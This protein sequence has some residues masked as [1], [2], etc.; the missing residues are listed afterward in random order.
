V[1]ENMGGGWWGGVPAMGGGPPSLRVRDVG[2]T[3]AWRGVCLL[4][5][6][7]DSVFPRA[8]S[9][10]LPSAAV[11]LLLKVLD[12]RGRLPETRWGSSF[13][14]HFAYG[15]FSTVVGLVLLLRAAHAVSWFWEGH[16][17]RQR[18]FAGWFYASSAVLAF[19]TGSKAS[20]QTTASFDHRF[21]RFASLLHATA[22]GSLRSAAGA[23]FELLDPEGLGP[24][25]LA[26]VAEC[27]HPVTL[28]F[29]WITQLLVENV[30]TGVM[31]VPAPILSRAFEELANG[32]VAYRD[33]RTLQAASFFPFPYLQAMTW[34]LVAHWALTPC[35]MCVWTTLPAWAFASTLV[36]VFFLWSLHF[37]AIEIEHPFQNRH[38][39]VAAEELHREF[40]EQLLLLVDARTRQMPDL[41]PVAIAWPREPIVHVPETGTSFCAGDKRLVDPAGKSSTELVRAPARCVEAGLVPGCRSPGGGSSGSEVSGDRRRLH[42]RLVS[43]EAMENWRWWGIFSR[44]FTRRG[45]P[46]AA[47]PAVGRGVPPPGTGPS[48]SPVTVHCPVDGGASRGDAMDGNAVLSCSDS[49]VKMDS[50]PSHSKVTSVMAV[51]TALLVQSV[52]E[53]GGPRRETFDGG[54]GAPAAGSRPLSS[55]PK[56]C[57]LPAPDVAPPLSLPGLVEF[58]PAGPMGLSA[59]EMHGSEEVQEI[60]L[61]PDGEEATVPDGWM[62][63]SGGQWQNRPTAG[64]MERWTSSLEKI[65]EASNEQEPG[66]GGSPCTP[67][68]GAA[69]SAAALLGSAGQDFAPSMPYL[70]RPSGR[71]GCPQAWEL[72]DMSPP[73]A[74]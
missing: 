41:A 54:G 42:Q 32:M 26:A 59:Q 21:T 25:S 12:E 74:P 15:A 44:L 45:G 72:E 29:Q 65:G 30:Q 55:P 43:L 37:L 24:D 23:S 22:A 36:H 6:V 20:R 27:R 33:A 71:G 1:L 19:A 5:R 51:E 40:N 9:A 64:T 56:L 34:L 16:R 66:C 11:A 53:G 68:P 63:W 3:S 2:N 61:F 48:W 35:V 46:C 58:D 52:E 8:L 39:S 28:V 10:S 7:R 60:V 47:P 18:M 49:V 17:A 50:C 69:A 13:G 14:G 73:N 38:S 57:S 4:F 70:K 62:T 67:S 31:G